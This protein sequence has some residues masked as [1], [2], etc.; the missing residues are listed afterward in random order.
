MLLAV[1]GPCEKE[2]RVG[3]VEAVVFTPWG[4]RVVFLDLT[5]AYDT[6]WHCGLHLKLMRI[7]L[8]Q[9][10]VRFIMEMLV[11]CSFI[12]HTSDGQTSKLRR[13][14]NGVPQGSVLSPMLFNIY[15][16]D[17]PDTTATKYGYAEDLAIMLRRP[18]WKALEDG[19][20][21]DMGILADYFQKWHLQLSVG[22]TVTAAYHLNNRKARRELDVYVG[23]NRLEFQQAPKYLGVRLDWTLSY[24]QHLDELKAKVMARVSLFR[25]LAGSTWGASPF[26][27]RISMQA[28]VLPAAEYC[29]PAWSR[30][31]HVNKVDTAINSTLQIVTGCLKPTPASYLPVLAGIAPASLRRDAA[32]LTLARKT[33]K[34][35]WHILY[36]ATIT[37][38]TPG[39]LE[40]RHPYN[41][42][43]QEMLVY[44]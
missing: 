33:Q 38:A 13:L 31:P 9:H 7:I 21:S 32:T 42:A 35:D 23:K 25:R 28:L 39:R 11:N 36:K 22:K 1:D 16:H 3:R 8:D 26:P 44:S 14:K 41:K 29:A 18:T 4:A 20:N 12:V 34:H 24:K 15:I 43:S 6:L 27:L 40:S 19:L 17:L 30:S 37:S 10:M 5:T 2:P